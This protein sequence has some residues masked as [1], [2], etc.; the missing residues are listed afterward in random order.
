MI[1][2]L[3]FHQCKNQADLKNLVWFNSLNEIEKQ[4]VLCESKTEKAKL[5]KI[6]LDRI[7]FNAQGINRAGEKID[8]QAIGSI[9]PEGKEKIHNCADIMYE[10]KAES[11]V[12]FGIPRIQIITPKKQWYKT[13]SGQVVRS[14][15]TMTS[16]QKQ[17][18]KRKYAVIPYNS[19]QPTKAIRR[20]VVAIEKAGKKSPANS[21]L[22]NKVNSNLE[23]QG[24]SNRDGGCI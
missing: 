1:T 19:P 23:S 12:W 15:T 22:I 14:M 11:I 6:K 13:V 8:G 4:I 24:L 9:I 18:K 7:I 21:F 2:K 10:Y 20:Q 5:E 17:Q 3:M 16:D